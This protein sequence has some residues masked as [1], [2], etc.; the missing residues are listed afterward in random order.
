[1]NV[2]TNQE[3]RITNHKKTDESSE[4]KKNESQVKQTRCEESGENKLIICKKKK[5]SHVINESWVKQ[6]KSGKKN[7]V[8]INESSINDMWKQTE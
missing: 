8:T 3:K 7:H 1:M 6:I 5:K 4:K 2:K